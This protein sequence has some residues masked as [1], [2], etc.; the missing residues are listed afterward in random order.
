MYVGLSICNYKY[1]ITLHR[2]LDISDIGFTYSND[3]DHSSVT[4]SS[5]GYC[6]E[7]MLSN[8]HYVE[9][10]LIQLLKS[11]PTSETS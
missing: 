1:Y 6:F 3:C 2:N 5:L 11:K 10:T 9:I 7:I 4:D 8:K